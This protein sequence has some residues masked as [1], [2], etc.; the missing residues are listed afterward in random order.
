MKYIVIISKSQGYNKV[1]ALEVGEY[2]IFRQYI[3]SNGKCQYKEKTSICGPIVHSES[4]EIL[5]QC[6]SEEKA[7]A[8]YA[9][10]G[11]KICA[12]C[13][14]ERIIFQNP[15]EVYLWQAQYMFLFLLLV[16]LIF[17]ELIFQYIP[18]YT[19]LSNS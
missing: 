3:N 4:T 12:N 17:L 11:R 7:R 14:K 6:L 19:L 8:T 9:Q 2:H 1:N 10:L 5:E 13:I 18:S 15:I 16:V